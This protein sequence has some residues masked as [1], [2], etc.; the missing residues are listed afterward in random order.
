M[1][2]FFRRQPGG[3]HTHTPMVEWAFKKKQNL[4]QK[5]HGMDA[6][7]EKSN[8]L[9]FFSAPTTKHSFSCNRCDVFEKEFLSDSLFLFFVLSSFHQ[10]SPS[11]WASAMD[12]FFR[13]QPGGE[14]TDTPTVE[15]TFKNNE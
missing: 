13:R 8:R 15:L 7:F 3:K 9:D 2:Q 6:N 14:H 11:G 1:D 5:E 4:K 10:C 12:Q